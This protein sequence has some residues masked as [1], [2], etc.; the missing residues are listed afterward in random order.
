MESKG[1]QVIKR[2]DGVEGVMGLKV[3][4]VTSGNNPSEH[5]PDGESCHT[6][7]YA[8][9]YKAEVFRIAEGILSSLYG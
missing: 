8:F 3:K 6:H 2:H 1:P 9:N 5:I 4:C 7:W